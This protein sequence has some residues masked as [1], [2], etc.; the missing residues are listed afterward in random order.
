MLRLFTTSL[1]QAA[2]QDSVTDGSRTIF[3]FLSRQSHLQACAEAR[4]LGG[5]TAFGNTT[6]ELQPGKWLIVKAR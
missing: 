6:N 3:L 4:V 2:A 1:L 5:K